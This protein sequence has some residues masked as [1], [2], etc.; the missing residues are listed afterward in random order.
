MRKVFVLVL[1]SLIVMLTMPL[2]FTNVA[3]ADATDAGYI[4]IT[5]E[6]AK[7]MMGENQNIVILDVGTSTEYKSGHIAGSKLIPLLELE[8]R[9]NAIDGNSAVIVYCG[10]GVKSEKASKILLDHGFD[11]VYNIRGGLNAWQDAG[12]PVVSGSTANHI[13][14]SNDSLSSEIEEILNSGKPVFLFLYVDWCHFCQQQ[15]PIIDELEQEYKEKITFFRVNCEEHPKAMKEFGASGYPSMF[16]MDKGDDEQYESQYF[17]GFTDKETLKESI[18]WIIANGSINKNSKDNELGIGA[19]PTLL[20]DDEDY[21]VALAGAASCPSSAPG[22]TPRDPGI[23]SDALCRGACGGD[24]PITCDNLPDTRICVSDGE[25]DFVCSYKVITCGSHLGCREHDACYDACATVIFP[26]ICRRLCD[27]NCIEDYGMINCSRWALGLGPYDR[28]IEFSYPPDPTACVGSTP[29]CVDGKC[30]E[31]RTNVDCDVKDG[32]Y[33]NEANDHN[34]YFDYYCADSKCDSYHITQSKNCNDYDGWHCA[35]GGEKRQKWDGYCEQGSLLVC[36]YDVLVEEDCD[37]QGGEEGRGD[38]CYAYGNGCEDRDY[39]CSDGSCAYTYSNRHT[40][41][42]D[43]WIY[44]CKGGDEVWKHRLFHDFY[45]EGGTCTDHTSWEDDQL[46]EDCNQY[47]GWVCDGNIRTY[48]N[49]VCIEGG[50]AC[51]YPP[52]ESEDCDD[53]DGWYPDGASAEEYRDYRCFDGECVYDVTDHRCN[54]GFGNCDGD[55]SNGCEVNLNTD[56]NNC[57]SCGNACDPGVTC[58]NGECCGE[59]AEGCCKVPS[60]CISGYLYVAGGTIDFS[61]DIGINIIPHHF[62]FCK[63]ILG[64][65]NSPYPNTTH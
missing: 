58:E 26:S 45:C 27:S 21:I 65:Q 61:S 43:D 36:D 3:L 39:F 22:V 59:W 40:D 33:C 44:Y 12:F 6:E 1:V 10:S 57:G 35:G 30:V 51:E 55:W 16:L 41:Y 7:Q 46:V 8:E 54:A 49:G 52:P 62:F 53:K 19:S 17:K 24:C 23:P 11:K 47:E 32:W 18:Y 9:I 20:I 2:I 64:G 37:T 4:T 38:G 31:C 50:C 25:H 60:G 5:A 48:C 56:S 14:P 13:F 42:Y 29:Y 15:I 63:R 34:Y 28:W